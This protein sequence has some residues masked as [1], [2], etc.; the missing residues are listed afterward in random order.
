MKIETI[1]YFDVEQSV[2]E[3]PNL[4]KSAPI[5]NSKN[6]KMFERLRHCYEELCQESNG[7]PSKS[8]IKIKDMQKFL[9]NIILMEIVSKDCPNGSPYFYRVVGTSLRDL[10]G[11]EMSMKCL[12]DQSFVN[13]S[14]HMK[15]AFQLVE[16]EKAPLF[17]KG[18]I[19][20]TMG[21]DG[22]VILPVNT[23]VLLLPFSNNGETVDHILGAIKY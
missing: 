2:D 9:D 21:D 19:A 16:S 10:F 14:S 8:A 15:N 20:M 1:K 5:E 6:I 12:D 23:H 7:L 18:A 11:E 13:M 17:L 3:N 22:N 4:L